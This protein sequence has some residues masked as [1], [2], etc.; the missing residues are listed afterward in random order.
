[1]RRPEIRQVVVTALLLVAFAVV[2][3]GLVAAT[4][5]LTAE[6][7]EK[8]EKRALMRKLTQI[9]PEARIDNDLTRDTIRIEAASRL[10]TDAPSTAYVGRRDGEPV[11]IIF[12]PVAPDGYN[13]NIHLLVGVNVDGSIAGVRVV[14]HRE[15]P[16]LG[17][18]IEARK[19]DWI[20]A[21]AGKSLDNPD[22][23]GWAVKRDGGEF[24][25]F[26]GATITPRAVVNAVHNTLLYFEANRQ[27][28]L[29]KAERA[30]ESG[31]E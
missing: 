13:G 31:D 18:V 16:G 1:M 30:Q 9:V 14:K 2:G 8:N 25:Q 7:I 10:G 27:R 28:L 3:V 5:S 19:S 21:F 23:K 17:D 6:R 29:A 12:T 26:T 15:T 24:D 20:R 22:E 4:Q 11:A